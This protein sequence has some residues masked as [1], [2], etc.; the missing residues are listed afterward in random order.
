MLVSRSVSV[1]GLMMM[2]PSGGRYSAAIQAIDSFFI[3]LLSFSLFLPQVNPERLRA[4]GWE[5]RSFLRL[6][7]S[8]SYEC[9]S[10]IATRTH[11]V[12]AADPSAD[13]D[14]MQDLL[15]THLGLLA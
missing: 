3:S 12:S 8:Y 1:A 13:I 4:G 2:L 14:K 11:K 6:L 9:H 10:D 5:P 7:E 15:C